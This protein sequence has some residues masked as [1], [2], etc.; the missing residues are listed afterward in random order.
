MSSAAQP[1][2]PTW[3]DFDIGVGYFGIVLEDAARTYE[4][5]AGL[6]VPECVAVEVGACSLL[7]VK[8]LK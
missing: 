3:G 7:S 1:L 6:K 4:S 5:K 8:C 2:V